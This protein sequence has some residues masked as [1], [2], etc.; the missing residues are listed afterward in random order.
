MLSS[1][2]ALDPRE[3]GHHHENIMRTRR[4]PGST[5]SFMRTAWDPLLQIWNPV[6]TPCCQVKPWTPGS[7]ATILQPWFTDSCPS[8]RLWA[9]RTGRTHVRKEVKLECGTYNIRLKVGGWK[10]WV[11][12][13][14]K[15]A[16][17]HLIF[18]NKAERYLRQLDTLEHGIEHE[19]NPE[20]G[21]KYT[22]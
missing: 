13:L 14:L 1:G 10:E 20:V 5:A 3:H 21:N 22:E 8:L 4:W 17:S 12:Y 15:A 11:L 6:S 18:I 9:G 7:T 19:E 2:K 16:Q